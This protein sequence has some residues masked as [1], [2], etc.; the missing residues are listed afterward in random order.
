MRGTDF[1]SWTMEEMLEAFLKEL[2]L[3]EDH[4]QVVSVSAGSQG[5]QK[6]NAFRSRDN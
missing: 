5:G 1:L 4:S 3:R 6:Q 2:E